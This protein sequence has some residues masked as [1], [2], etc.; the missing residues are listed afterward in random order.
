VIIR[1][2]ALDEKEKIIV[3]RQAVFMYPKAD[4]IKK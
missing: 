2:Y 3:D 1:A 4:L